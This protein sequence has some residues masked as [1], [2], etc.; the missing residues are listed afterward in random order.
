MKLLKRYANRRLYDADTSQTI[1]LDDVARLISEGHD[2]QIIDNVSG[3]DI[4]SRVLGQ[5]FLKVS[6][7]HY[8]LDFSNYLLSALIREVKTNVSGLFSQLIG[9]GIGLRHLTRDKLENIVRSMVEHGDVQL[10]EHHDYL[11]GLMEQ[12]RSGHHEIRAKA[13]QG[14]EILRT[15]L[16]DD[17]ERKVEEL[18]GKLDEMARLLS[19]LKSGQSGA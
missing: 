8:N 2:V 11:G 18:S 4:T 5:T 7:D 19:E 12:V 3:Q 17:Q 14:R 15:G 13:E 6:T 16:G 10:T 1:T 9:S